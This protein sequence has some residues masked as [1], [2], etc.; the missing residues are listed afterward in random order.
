MMIFDEEFPKLIVITQEST[1]YATGQ[2]E[3]GVATSN[4]W[5]SGVTDI[6]FSEP[7]EGVTD[8]DGVFYGER[9]VKDMITGMINEGG[10]LNDNWRDEGLE[11]SYE[12]E[13]F[14]ASSNLTPTYQIPLLNKG[15]QLNSEDGCWQSKE[16][17]YL[18]VVDDDCSAK[19]YLDS[20]LVYRAITEVGLQNI[21][22][23]IDFISLIPNPTKFYNDLCDA[24]K[25]Y[26]EKMT[27]GQL[28]NKMN[29]EIKS[30]LPT[31]RFDGKAQ[32]QIIELLKSHAGSKPVITSMNH[33]TKKFSA[34]LSD[35][36]KFSRD[37]K[38][39]PLQYEVRLADRLDGYNL[40]IHGEPHRV[41][42][43][44]ELILGSDKPFLSNAS[45]FFSD[46]EKTKYSFWAI[47]KDSLPDAKTLVNKVIKKE[48]NDFIR[49]NKNSLGRQVGFKH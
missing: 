27:E 37:P 8:S 10:Q 29:R 49:A 35:S 45:S 17:K 9:I 24:Y 6:T 20:S 32:T 39:R 31:V 11:L 18:I 21:L 41:D 44:H 42:N 2:V 40:E 19:V 16:N 47:N 15:Y 28:T 36:L 1:Y 46:D 34:I 38:N 22:N 25:R 13:D 5:L 48:A 14:N 30:L 23:N 3:H 4:R 12:I 33:F 43:V 7:F 26:A